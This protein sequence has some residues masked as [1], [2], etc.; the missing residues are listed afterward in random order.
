MV[1]FGAAA[2]VDYFSITDSYDLLSNREAFFDAS[3]VLPSSHAGALRRAL[4]D[5]APGQLSDAAQR[6]DGLAHRHAGRPAPGRRRSMPPRAAS[7]SCTSAPAPAD[8]HRRPVPRS[9]ARPDGIHWDGIETTPRRRVEAWSD[10]FRGST[11]AEPAHVPV[12][13]LR[14]SRRPASLSGS[15]VAWTAPSPARSCCATG[16]TVHLP[17][18]ESSE[19]IFITAQRPERK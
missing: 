10:A 6:H 18:P 1:D 13:G 16:S 7:L 15:F 17:M 5:A 3:D 11:S 8:P 2:H 19:L 12:R 14:R 4:A 9:P